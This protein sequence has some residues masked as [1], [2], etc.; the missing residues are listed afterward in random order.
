MFIDNLSTRK[1]H[2]KCTC[3]RESTKEKGRV[4]RKGTQIKSRDTV[5]EREIETEQLLIM[6][7]IRAALA[8]WV[9]PTA[10]D[11]VHLAVINYVHILY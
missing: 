7:V 4:R 5:R 3:S 6:W 9:A 2:K 11:H 8:T 10:V 1:C